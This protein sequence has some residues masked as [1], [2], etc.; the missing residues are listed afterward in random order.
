MSDN[1]ID[2]YK[3]EFLDR[4]QEPVAGELKTVLITIPIPEPPLTF[5]KTFYSVH[6]MDGLYREMIFEFEENRNGA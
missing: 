2:R 3:K 4:L 1:S 5:P 6:I